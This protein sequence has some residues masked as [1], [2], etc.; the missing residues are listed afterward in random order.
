MLV[1]SGVLS[2]DESNSAVAQF[3]SYVVEKRRLHEGSDVN[4]SEIPDIVQY[5]LRDFSFHS[6]PDVCRV[7]KLCCLV[8]GLPR[9]SYTLG[10]FFYL[11]SRLLSEAAFQ[12]RSQLVQTYVMSTGYCHQL[13]FTDLTLDAI[14]SANANAD[15]F[16]ITPGYDIGRTFVIPVLCTPLLPTIRI[17]IVLERRESSVNHCVECN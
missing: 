13:F 7:L 8:I 4:A 10:F 11:S 16:Y 17:C 14:W 9:V 6:R 15:V 12:C 2:S 1:T 5:L 3:S